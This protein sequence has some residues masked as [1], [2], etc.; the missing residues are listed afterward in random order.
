[1][2]WKPLKSF[3]SGWRRHAQAALDSSP[4]AKRGF[5]YFCRCEAAAGID[6]P[7]KPFLACLA[8]NRIWQRFSVS[9]DLFLALMHEILF[10]MHWR[11][12]EKQRYSFRRRWSHLLCNCIIKSSVL[13][14]GIDFTAVLVCLS[15]PRRGGHQETCSFAN[16]FWNSFGSAFSLLDE[17]SVWNAK[18]N[19]DRSIYTEHHD[20][21]RA[22]QRV[23]L[24]T[25][26]FMFREARRASMT[27]LIYLSR[28]IL[29]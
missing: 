29:S 4:S 5:I 9:Q 24:D 16:T 3:S 6:Q 28:C 19:A 1:M 7:G 23:Q 8:G 13:H 12:L 27:R 11:G 20:G 25:A 18:G 14:L 22:A 17:N 26:G 2:C 21:G 15:V 10:Q